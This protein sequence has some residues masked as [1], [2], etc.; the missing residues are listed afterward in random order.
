M[1]N[2][3]K[4]IAKKLPLILLSSLFSLAICEAGVRLLG[5]RFTGS[6]FTTDPLLGW[7]LRPGAS[8]W[9][10]DEGVS[11]VRINSHG[12][13]DRERTVSKPPGVFRVAVVGDSF[14][15]ARQV[16]LEKSFTSLAEEELN[17]RNCCGG[18][19]VEVLNFGTLGYNTGQ[20]F[21]L[22]RERVWKF[23]PDMVILEFFAGNDIIDNNRTL[24]TVLPDM[25]PSFHLRNGKLELDDGF[26]RGNRFDPTYIRLK[27]FTM[28]A[29]NKS[30]LALM[31]YKLSSAHAQQEA[32]ERDTGRANALMESTDPNAPPPQYSRFIHFLPPKIPVMVEAWQV[33]EALIAEFGKEVQ[34]HHVPLLM[35][36]MPQPIQFHPDPNE[37]E[38]FRARYKVES[39]EY[40]DD[41]VEQ[42]ARANGFLTLRLLKPLIEEARRTGTYMS[43]FANSPP[44]EFHLN[45]RGHAVVAREMVR[46]ICEIIGKGAETAEKR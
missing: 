30:V 11:W 5:Y 40:A 4:N 26:R 13:R 34:S 15:E 29:V 33:T 16:D 25:L 21:L 44:N 31:A 43:G 3:V 27:G 45:E 2:V 7:S 37:Q 18:R 1:M 10:V 32:M 17:R 22:L 8:G 19:R 36:I 35:M 23:D 6:F 39:F 12:Y 38:A 24:N 46:A 42:Q 28:N 14:T 41:R 9:Q 20:E